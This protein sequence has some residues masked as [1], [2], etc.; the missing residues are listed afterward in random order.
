[1][2]S[3]ISNAPVD[4]CY[5]V[6]CNECNKKTWAVSFFLP[7][8]SVPVLFQDCRPKP[9]I[10]DSFSLDKINI[11]ILILIHLFIFFCRVAA[12]TRRRSFRILLQKTC[13][14]ARVISSVRFFMLVFPW[15]CF[16]SF[17]KII[18]SLFLGFSLSKI[19]GEDAGW[20]CIIS[21]RLKIGLLDISNA[22]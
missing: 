8:L 15:L 3:A 9:P 2:A 13:A 17:S 22:R 4:A 21:Q 5:E 1:M 14:L 11:N 6:T 12:P 19:V 7:P 10:P 18:D 20:S 16:A